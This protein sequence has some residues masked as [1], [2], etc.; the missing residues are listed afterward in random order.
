MTIAKNI[1]TAHTSRYRMV[2]PFMPFLGEDDNGKAEQGE[3]V[4]LM[5]N[6]VNLPGLT[7]DVLPI[8]TPYLEQKIPSNRLAFDDLTLT[9]AIDELF[10]N[11]KM[12]YDWMTLIKHP[13]RYSVDDMIV[14]ASLFIYSN[15]N[16]PKLE[17]KLFRIFP[18]ALDAITFTTKVDDSDDLECSVTFA[19]EWMEPQEAL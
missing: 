19:V 5:C 3:G 10:E 18:F 1:S 2:F 14:D 6:E 17:F 8:E 7:L 11:Y 9:F 16:N 4:T 15:N 13:E 12:L